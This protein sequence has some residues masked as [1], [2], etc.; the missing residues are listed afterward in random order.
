MKLTIT[1]IISEGLRFFHYTLDYF[2]FQNKIANFTGANPS[3]VKSFYEK[4]HRSEIDKLL[5]DKAGLQKEG[6]LNF[7]MLNRTRGPLLYLICKLLRPEIVV[8]TGVANGFSST[9]ILKALME[10]QKGKLYSIDFPNQP[11][12]EI[13][14]K[15]GWLIPDDLRSRWGLIIGDSKQELPALIEKLGRIDVFF[16]D[17]DH[18]YEHILFELNTAWDAI[19][20]G[21]V[22]LA[23]DVHMNRAYNDFCLGKGIADNVI[24]KL[25]IAVKGS[26]LPGKEKKKRKE[27]EE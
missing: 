16:H 2:T 5:R 8:E 23:D 19:A 25:G 13:N 7:D 10:N 4:I 21:G 9:L 15:I 11:G 1:K 22:A 24:Y 6:F 3:T 14:N 17:S 12:H 18:S 20:E 27:H 26:N